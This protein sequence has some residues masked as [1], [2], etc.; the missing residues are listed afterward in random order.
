MV[1]DEDLILE[2]NSYTF[3]YTSRKMK[4]NKPKHPELII[5]QILLRLI[6]VKRVIFSI[7]I[8]S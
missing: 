4:Q 1:K 5:K 3:N 8:T 7:Y 2:F 6:Q